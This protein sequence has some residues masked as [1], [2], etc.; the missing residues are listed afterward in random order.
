[1]TSWAERF[2]AYFNARRDHDCYLEAKGY[3]NDNGVTR[4]EPTDPVDV[5]QQLQF[6]PGAMARGELDYS[7]F[8]ADN[9]EPTLIYEELD[10]PE[11]F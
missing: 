4:W 9:D 11:E 8:Y 6:G 3:Y 10:E 7:E 5:E 2:D 1:M